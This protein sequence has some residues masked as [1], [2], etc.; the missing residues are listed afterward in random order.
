MKLYDLAVVGSGIGG[1][2]IASLNKDKNTIIFEKDKNLGGCASTFKRYG[3]Y[4]NAGA[5]TF[6]GYEEDHPIKEIFDKANYK[7]DITKSDIAIRIIQ[8]KKVIDRIKDFDKFIED[9]NKA[10]PN[11]NNK[12]FWQKIKDIDEKFWQLKK[13]YYSKYSLNAYIKT[14]NSFIELFSTLIL[15]HLKVQKVL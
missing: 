4:F 10:Y 8:N 3:S 6:V 2:M 7:P 5:T 14:I 9:I 13:L 11:K 1:S 12:I 15:T